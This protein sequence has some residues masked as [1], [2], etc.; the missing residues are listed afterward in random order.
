MESDTACR[1]SL[2]PKLLYRWCARSMRLSSRPRKKPKTVI[3]KTSIFPTGSLKSV[4]RKS[5]KVTKSRASLKVSGKKSMMMAHNTRAT[6]PVDRKM[7]W[8]YTVGMTA[9]FTRATLGRM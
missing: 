9:L 2:G 3:Q 1:K 7:A 6:L 5:R 4:P 8:V